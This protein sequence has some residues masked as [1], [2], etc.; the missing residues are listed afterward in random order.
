MTFPEIGFQ[1]RKED[2]LKQAHTGGDP[3]G[4]ER[5]IN[6]QRKLMRGSDG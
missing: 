1:L 3:V 6:L 4:G 5:T 2:G